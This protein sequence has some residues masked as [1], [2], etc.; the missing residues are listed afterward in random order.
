VFDAELGWTNRANY[1]TPDGGTHFNSIA[2]RGQREYA[3]QPPPGIL[4]IACFGESFTYGAQGQDKDTFEQCLERAHPS[5]EALNFGVSGFGTDQALLR[6]R[7]EGRTLGA[8]VVVLGLM[9]ENIGRNVNRYKDCWQPRGSSPGAKP[10][11]E[12]VGGE[13]ALVPIPFRT[14]QEELDAV[15]AGTIES[16]LAEHEYWREPDLPGWLWRSSLV[17]IGATWFDSRRRDLRHQWT[18]ADDEPYQ[19]TRALIASFEREALA[20]G[21]RHF[22]VLV[23]PP[24]PQLRALARGGDRY[25]QGMLDDLARSG[26]EA[27]DACPL[28]AQG[29]DASLDAHGKSGLY[30]EKHLSGAGNALVAQALADWLEQ[31]FP[32]LKP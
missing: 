15:A 17:R 24:E 9:L 8:H 4:R 22:C 7:R 11:F 23:L 29:Y 5:L 21:A 18:H 1:A 32:G 16:Q 3:A 10:R 25:W 30:T 28:L 20:G 26:V 31:R 14:Q 19:V 27:L 13:L 6:F 12:L 2:A